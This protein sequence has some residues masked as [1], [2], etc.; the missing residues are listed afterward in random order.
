MGMT[1]VWTVKNVQHEFN[2]FQEEESN[3][4]T[5]LMGLTLLMEPQMPWFSKC[6][7]FEAFSARQK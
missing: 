4:E 1:S 2:T 5:D 7:P 3:E 6:F